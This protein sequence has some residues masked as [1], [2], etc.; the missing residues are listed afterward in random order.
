M[1]SVLINAVFIS[2]ASA[3]VLVEYE[4]NFGHKIVSSPPTAIP[5]LTG[6]IAA[7][8]F[9]ASDFRALTIRDGAV[10]ADQWESASALT[11]CYE[12]AVSSVNE[13]D[14]FNLGKLTFEDARQNPNSPRN[15][16]VTIN[17][18]FVASGETHDDFTTNTLDLSGEAFQGLTSARVKIYA[19]NSS[20]PNADW[21]L[22]N[23]KLEGAAVPE[24]DEYILAIS[25]LLAGFAGLRQ[26]MKSSEKTGIFPG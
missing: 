21:S 25:L 1:V 19:F 20:N 18:L 4:F 12:F 17:D 23:V 5:E 26:W 24:P 13:G 9:T 22:K 16:T 14:F 2:P 7:E 11:T 6:S 10:F 15:W 3:V 8:N